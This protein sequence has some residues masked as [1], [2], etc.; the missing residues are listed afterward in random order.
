[1]HCHA[2]LALAAYSHQ[3]NSNLYLAQH[4]VQCMAEIRLH[5]LVR[6]STELLSRLQSPSVVSTFTP[7]PETY[8]NPAPYGVAAYPV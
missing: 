4:A 6:A 5:W 1:M 7:N 2:L 8:G 3:P